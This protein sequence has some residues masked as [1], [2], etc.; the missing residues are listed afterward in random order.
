M[1]NSNP[2]LLYLEYHVLGLMKEEGVTN[3]REML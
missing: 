3:E 2:A 1:L